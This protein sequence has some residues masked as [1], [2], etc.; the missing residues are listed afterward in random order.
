MRYKAAI[1]AAAAAGLF[2]KGVTKAGTAKWQEN[3]LRKGATR[4]PE[5]I[6]LSL[7]AYVKGFEPFRRVIE[8]TV[9]PEPGAK[10]SAANYERSKV[11]GTALHE[12]KKRMKGA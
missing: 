4:W 2:G 7:D 8:T 10:N 12:A 1:A 6:A 3:S 9:L 5:G 11:M